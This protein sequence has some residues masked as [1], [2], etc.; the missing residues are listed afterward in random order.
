[1]AEY[2]SSKCQL[3]EVIEDRIKKWGRIVTR[4]TCSEGEKSKK[5]WMKKSEKRHFQLFGDILFL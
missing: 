5:S 2:A 1:M 3:L 4:I